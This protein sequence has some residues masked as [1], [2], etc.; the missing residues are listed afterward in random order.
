MNVISAH[1]LL[2]TMEKAY[3]VHTYR[4]E[5]R[6]HII[7]IYEMVH[8]APAL[9]YKFRGSQWAADVA[10]GF[11]LHHEGV[12]GLPKS[13]P[14]HEGYTKIAQALSWEMQGKP[15]LPFKNVDVAWEDMGKGTQVFVK[16]VAKMMLWLA[17]Q[18]SEEKE[19]NEDK[20]LSQLREKIVTKDF[21]G[22]K[23][24]SM[25]LQGFLLHHRNKLA[26]EAATAEKAPVSLIW[27]A[28]HADGM[29]VL[30]E[31]KGYEKQ[32][33]LALNGDNSLESFDLQRESGT[34]G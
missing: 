22:P 25:V 26:V 30:L 9:F 20:H 14:L 15:S 10:Q 16:V 8:I 32:H 5:D 21:K 28:A 3:E 33:A 19:D 24:F 29:G 1:H 6:K 34:Y 2:K 31:E 23:V 11:I 27:G 17:K 13:V 12:V 4:H 7:K 18:L